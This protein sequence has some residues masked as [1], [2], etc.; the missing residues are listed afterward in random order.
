[1]QKKFATTDD[2]II[3]L[4]LSY[5]SN[6]SLRLNQFVPE[7]LTPVFVSCSLT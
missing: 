7:K 1:M 5:Y 6:E 4:D 3:V 2:T